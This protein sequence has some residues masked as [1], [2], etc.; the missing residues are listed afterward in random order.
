MIGI[1]QAA[2]ASR[3]AIQASISAFAL[4]PLRLTASGIGMLSTT[5]QTSGERPAGV[6]SI[7]DLR[8]ETS[9]SVQARPIGTWCSEETML[10]APVWRTSSSV[11][12][13]S[14]PNHLH[15]CRIDFLLVSRFYIFGF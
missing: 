4:P 3:L 11:T 1:S 15:P 6:V 2:T 14:G 9:F 13:A 5:D 12:G 7:I 10:V 8:S